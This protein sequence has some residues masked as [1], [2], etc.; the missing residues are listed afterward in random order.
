MQLAKGS[1]WDEVTSSSEEIKPV[2]IAIVELRLAEGISPY[3][4]VLYDNKGYSLQKENHAKDH[5][6]ND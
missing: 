2:Y 3:Y 5:T 4:T 6:L 1:S